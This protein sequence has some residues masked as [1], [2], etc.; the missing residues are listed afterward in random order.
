MID[1]RAAE[2]ELERYLDDYD[3]ENDKVKLKIVHTYGVVEQSTEIA[4]RM[5]ISA[6]DRSLARIIA[7][8]HDIGRFEQLKRYDSFM[9]D[10]MDHAAYGVQVLFREKMIR[11]FVPE[12][13]WDN[14]IETAIARHS[15]FVLEGI[16]DERA[17]LHA[18]IIRDADKL[19][20]C[21]VKLVDALETFM[22]AGA[23]EIG[24]TA[25]S[26]VIRKDALEGRSILS[27]DRVTLMDYWVSY[28]AY[29]YDLNFRESLDI[30]DENDYVHRIIQRIP[31]T[32]P[33]TAETMR[34]LE[35][36][37]TMYIREAKRK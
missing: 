20:N 1:Y 35:K 19:D 23:D 27:A 31:Y 10:T 2:E 28:L 11:R 25:I 6:E 15:D 37:L 21:R 12:E 34:E 22:G 36:K 16:E 30:L 32:D 9:P 13:T 3:R 8:L 29:F 26:P 24:A 17:L 7:L 14:I 33:N 18:R 5:G 4:E